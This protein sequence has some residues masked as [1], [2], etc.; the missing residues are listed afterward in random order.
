M[1]NNTN[2]IQQ[3]TQTTKL[4]SFKDFCDSTRALRSIVADLD[5]MKNRYY[6]S[7]GTPVY[8]QAAHLGGSICSPQ[9]PSG[10]HIITLKS[11]HVFKILC[12]VATA[13]NLPYSVLAVDEDPYLLEKFG[14]QIH[15]DCNLYE[16]KKYLKRWMHE[17]DVKGFIGAEGRSDINPSLFW[18]SVV[19]L[20]FPDISVPIEYQEENWLMDL[21][22]NNQGN[23]F[24]S[25]DS[26]SNSWY[27]KTGS[28]F[29]T[30]C[31]DPCGLILTENNLVR[32]N[33]DDYTCNPILWDELIQDKPPTSRSQ[34]E[35]TISTINTH[36]MWDFEYDRAS[37]AI[38]ELTSRHRD[39]MYLLTIEACSIGPNGD[40]ST[41]NSQELH[42]SLDSALESVKEQFNLDSAELLLQC[43][44]S[45]GMTLFQNSEL[46]FHISPITPRG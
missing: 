3:D 7:D 46:S 17:D 32:W 22:T 23:H 40:G 34:I 42:T 28:L 31:Q 18:D 41:S 30:L 45:D 38:M 8:Y 1:P 37:K 21:T 25:L 10:N 44:H 39:I 36:C 15:T 13:C 20:Q 27:Q 26:E 14:D 43:S 6:T 12:T 5:K 35:D 29:F 16:M 4:T 33:E 19:I 24:F 11:S 2:T 9:A